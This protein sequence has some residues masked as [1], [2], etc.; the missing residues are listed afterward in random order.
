MKLAALAML[1]S[2]VGCSTTHY[3][4]VI[5]TDPADVGHTVAR[6]DVKI[7]RDPDTGDSTGLCVR[8]SATSGLLSCDGGY[9]PVDA[10][11]FG[12]NDSRTVFL[13]VPRDSD[14]TKV[15]HV[16]SGYRPATSGD[17]L[18]AELFKSCRCRS[19]GASLLANASRMLPP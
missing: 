14:A 9:C 3:G 12:R 6:V 8:L 17:V 15:L 5:D 18:T 2:V 7:H 10:F 13:R 1:L 16:Y 11:L 19:M 4:L